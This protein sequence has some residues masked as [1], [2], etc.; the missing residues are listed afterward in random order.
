MFSD[1]SSASGDGFLEK[2]TAV[3]EWI[4][5]Q[6]VGSLIKFKQPWNEEMEVT[7]IFV[8]TL[9]DGVWFCKDGMYEVLKTFSIK[10]S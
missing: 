7:T 2:A 10:L 3:L 9:I 6:P 5:I 8:W 1:Q 4:L